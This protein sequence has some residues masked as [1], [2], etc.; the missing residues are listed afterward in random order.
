MNIC[1]IYSPKITLSENQL[2]F[3]QSASWV[4]N[5]SKGGIEVTLFLIEISMFLLGKV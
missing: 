3:R 2:L 5:R 4:V 1:S